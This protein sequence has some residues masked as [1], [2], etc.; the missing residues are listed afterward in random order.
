MVQCPC[1]SGLEY[2]TCCEPYIEGSKKA[3]DPERLMR[4]RYTAYAKHRI[5]YLSDT[6]HPRSRK[7]HDPESTRQWSMKSEWLGLSVLGKEGGGP[8]ET[9]GTVEFVARYRTESQEVEH[10][11]RAEFRREGDTWYFVDG[12][13][14]G[15]EPIQREAPKVGRNDPCPCGS[16]KKYKRCCGAGS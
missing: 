13:M 5:S 7:T 11:E 1:D 3:P 12:K 15:E 2:S 14:V 10:H 4:S 16:G 9:T 6:L 8:G